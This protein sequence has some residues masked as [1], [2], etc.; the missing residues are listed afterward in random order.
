MGFALDS[1]P[2]GESS[3]IRS[4]HRQRPGW[5]SGSISVGSLMIATA[6]VAAV[7][8]SFEWDSMRPVP[9]VAWVNM[10][11]AVPIERIEASGSETLGR[12]ALDPALKAFPPGLKLGRGLEVLP[13]HGS[14]IVMVRRWTGRPYEDV[15]VVNAVAKSLA[16]SKAAKFG[17]VVAEGRL[18]PRAV[19][20]FHYF[21]IA[22]GRSILIGAGVLI[23]LKLLGLV[24]AACRKPSKTRP[25]SIGMT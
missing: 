15:A 12:A 21:L 8:A 13:M 6:A 24:A 11:R 17:K 5:L 25:H 18:S 20:P 2:D 23:L 10:G 14:T 3:M 1:R 22:L 7:L 16:R 9:P 19:R 4:T